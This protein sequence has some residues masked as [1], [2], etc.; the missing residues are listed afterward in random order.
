MIKKFSLH[1]ENSPGSCDLEKDNIVFLAKTTK[2]EREDLIKA[3][4]KYIN[5]NKGTLFAQ[6]VSFE[7]GRIKE[8]ASIFPKYK[9][10]LL[11][12]YNRGFDLLWLLNNN[13]ELYEK[14]GFAG[15]DLETFN[16]YDERLSG[17]FSIKKTLPVFSSLSYDNLDV[18]NG[19]E[20][21]VV[22]ANY[23]N[24]SKEELEKQQ[25]ALK[26][27]CR[28]DTWAMVEILNA[29]RKLVK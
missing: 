9:E 18:H 20:A 15:K 4:L 13:K 23:D 1:I 12:I 11:K 16:F 29:L 22:Y 2:D 21:I 7:K 8:L 5:P 19:T 27:Y 10:D 6:N 28:Q 17:S 26:I 24:Y 3:L 14:L 25:E